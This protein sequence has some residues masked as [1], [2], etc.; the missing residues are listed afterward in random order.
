MINVGNAI[1]LLVLH[2]YNF[3]DKQMSLELTILKCSNPRGY[4]IFICE[5][6]LSSDCFLYVKVIFVLFATTDLRIKRISKQT[7]FFAMGTNMRDIMYKCEFIIVV[8]Q[9]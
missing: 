4:L 2:T 3:K 5:K 7:Y 1:F 6:Y 8:Q 9:Y